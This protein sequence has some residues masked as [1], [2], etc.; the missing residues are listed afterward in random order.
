MIA[1]VRGDEC[2]V[3][4]MTASNRTTTP[5]TIVIVGG[6]F[7]GIEAA[8]RLG[9]LLRK[10]DAAQVI[11]ISNENYFLF[12]PLLPEVVACS[13]EPSHILNPIRHLCRNIQSAT[14]ARSIRSFP[15]VLNDSRSTIRLLK[16]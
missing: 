9:H 3:Q 5:V 6:G 14:C 10:D 1:A 2:L 8:S 12:Q 11:L 4:A 16:I 15:T 13:I 7:A